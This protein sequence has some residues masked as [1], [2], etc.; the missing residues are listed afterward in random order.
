MQIRWLFLFLL[1]LGVISCNAEPDQNPPE[2]G[3]ATY[4]RDF[5]QAATQS[6]KTGKPIFAFFQEVPG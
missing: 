2:V 6:Q 1:T 4:L 3:T 5:D